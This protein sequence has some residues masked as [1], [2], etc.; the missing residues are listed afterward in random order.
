MPQ[1]QL[2]ITLHCLGHFEGSIPKDVLDLAL[3][4]GDAMDEEP[5]DVAFDVLRCRGGAGID[6]TLELGGK[7]PA[8]RGLRRFQHGLGSTMRRMGFSEDRIRTRFVPHITLDYAHERVD[9]RTV[10]P[11]AWRV[12]QFCVVDSHYGQGRHEVLARWPLRARQQEFSDW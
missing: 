2:H 9:P 12:T 8:V 7:G 5:F 11:I 10:T 3:A 6:G 1:D 4:V